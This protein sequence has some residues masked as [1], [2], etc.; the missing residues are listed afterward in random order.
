ML[1]RFGLEIVPREGEDVRIAVEEVGTG[2]GYV[3]CS[4]NAA[5]RVRF[6]GLG[7][8]GED[9]KGSKAGRRDVVVLFDPGVGDAGP[10]GRVAEGAMVRF[11]LSYPKR[12]CCR[13]VAVDQLRARPRMRRCVSERSS[14]LMSRKAKSQQAETRHTMYVEVGRGQA[15]GRG[16]I[17]GEVQ[18]RLSSRDSMQCA[19]RVARTVPLFTV[20][21]RPSI[22]ARLTIETMRTNGRNDDQTV[23]MSWQ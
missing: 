4:S 7:N 1:G 19:L 21:G 5:S 12:E 11:P 13:E 18:L 14:M 9:E 10:S 2:V 6:S 16:R 20:G 15:K 17:M 22:S 8:A 23:Y 3:V